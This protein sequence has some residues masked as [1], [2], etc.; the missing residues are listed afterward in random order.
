MNGYETVYV[1]EKGLKQHTCRPK[2]RLDY[3]YEIQHPRG[4]IVCCDT[5]GQHW[6]SHYWG[7]WKSS[8][9]YT[10]KWHKV[11]WYQ[12]MKKRRILGK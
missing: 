4:T 6:F 3:G 9:L 8:G 11:R 5:C 12:F 1:P 10:V 7:R 2:E